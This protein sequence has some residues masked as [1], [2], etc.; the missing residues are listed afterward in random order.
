MRCLLA[1][2]LAIGCTSDD[3]TIGIDTGVVHGAKTGSV[4]SFVNIPFAAANRP[5]ERAE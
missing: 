4:R 3:L 5:C 2:I 1:L